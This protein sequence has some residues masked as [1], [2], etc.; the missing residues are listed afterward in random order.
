MIAIYKITNRLNNKPYVGQT[1]QRV[2]KR[3][4]Q[5]LN[6]NTPL[7]DD[8]RDCK[9]ENFTIEVIETCETQAQANDRE[10]FWIKVLDC[11]APKGYNQRDGG[12]G[13]H[14]PKA[15]NMCGI[16]EGCIAMLELYKR[17]RDRREELHLSQDELSKKVGY[18]SRTSIHKIEMGRTDFLTRRI[19]EDEA[20]LV[21]GYRKLN[22]EKKQL[23]KSIVFQFGDDKPKK[24]TANVSAKVI[25]G[26]VQ[27]SGGTNIVSV[28]SGS[29]NS[30]IM[31]Q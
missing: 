14:K 24:I 18:K 8:M 17:I 31:S 28:G 10:R 16:E 2:E 26:N 3:F 19:T 11:K 22:F 21:D 20:E 6:D 5:H 9:P 4:M 1:R 25:N 23:V 15:N 7:D 29:F 27:N 30:P 13:I 12:G